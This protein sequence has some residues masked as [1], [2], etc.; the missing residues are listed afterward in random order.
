MAF[1]SILRRATPLAIHAFKNQR[2]YSSAIFNPLKNTTTT[3]PTTTISRETFLRFSSLPLEESSE[4]HDIVDEEIKRGDLESG[5]ND[6]ESS[7]TLDLVDAEIKGDALEL[8]DHDGAKPTKFEGIGKKR[9]SKQTGIWTCDLC[10][11][12]LTTKKRLEVHR[13]GRNHKKKEAEMSLEKVA[14]EDIVNKSNTPLLTYNVCGVSTTSEEHL[15]NHYQGK[16]HK[17][18][19]AKRG[20]IGEAANTDSGSPIVNGGGEVVEANK[21]ESL[22]DL[23]KKAKFWCDTCNVGCT[24]EINFTVHKMGKKHNYIVAKRGL[25]GE[26]AYTDSGSPIVEANK[27]RSLEDLKKKAKFWCD[28]CNVGCTCE[29][30]FTVHK[31]GKKHKYIVAIRGLIGEGANTDSGSPTVNGGGEVVEANKK[32]SLEDLKKKAKFWCDTCNVGCTC[33]TNFT[34]HKMGKKHIANENLKNGYKF[35]CEV[36]KKGCNSEKNM[37][38]HR[39]GK[40]HNDRSQRGEDA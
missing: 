10:E 2:N 15:Q 23:K 3:R 21:K 24:C 32:Q 5:D 30:N 34:V 39:E 9:L 1:S 6:G 35:W 40:M 11:V 17:Y 18:K 7:A 38:D 26:A 8:K 19:V 29:T 37:I 14:T 31:M 36:C 4:E 33:E 25:I 22:E 16:K 13:E 28:T 12:N 20:L 27:K